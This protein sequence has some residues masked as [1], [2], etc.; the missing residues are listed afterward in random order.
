MSKRLAHLSFE[1]FLA[2]AA[3]HFDELY[4]SDLEQETQEKPFRGSVRCLIMHSSGWWP[5]RVQRLHSF[6]SCLWSMYSPTIQSFPERLWHARS[7]HSGTVPAG[8]AKRPMP[9]CYVVYT[10]LEPHWDQ[11][12]PHVATVCLWDR[13]QG[14]TAIISVFRRETLTE[15]ALT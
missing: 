13:S 11:P 12:A 2:D 1:G 8:R 6:I 15:S 7:I 9:T 4:W 10:H 14:T 3:M 5:Y